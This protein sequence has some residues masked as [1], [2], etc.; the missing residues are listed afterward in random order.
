[1]AYFYAVFALL[2]GLFYRELTRIHDFSGKTQLGVAHTHLFVLGM[3]VMLFVYLFAYTMKIHEEKWFTSFFI[4]YN[5]GVLV[6]TV[7]MLTRGTLQVMDFS[8][9]NGIDKMIAG[10]SGIGHILLT[11]GFIQ[12]LHMLRK[13]TIANKPPLS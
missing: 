11:I 10:M 8:I 9:S 13:R 5:L 3:F 2:S 12:F 7:M 4:I 6:S 1:M